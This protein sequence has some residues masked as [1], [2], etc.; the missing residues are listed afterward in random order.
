VVGSGNHHRP[1]HPAPEAELAARS[2]ANRA[3]IEQA[4]SAARQVEAR[5]AVL[6][7]HANPSLER[8]RPPAGFRPLHEDLRRVLVGYPGPVLAIHGDTHQFRFDQPLRDTRTGA[9]IERFWRLEVP[10]SPLAAGVW[11]TVEAAGA[12]EPFSVDVVD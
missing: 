10:G 6:I 4:I 3:L 9:P 11:V 7:F 8:S 2:A 1:G 12:A 5:A